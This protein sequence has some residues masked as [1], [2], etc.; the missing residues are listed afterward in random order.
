[1]SSFLRPSHTATSIAASSNMLEVEGHD[2]ASDRLLDR[3]LHGCLAVTLNLEAEPQEQVPVDV[4]IVCDPHACLR[5]IHLLESLR[6]ATPVLSGPAHEASCLTE[7]S[8]CLKF[9]PCRSLQSDQIDGWPQRVLSQTAHMQAL[10]Y[11]WNQKCQ[12]QDRACLE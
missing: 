6:S 7:P 11:K 2:S 1:M 4:R 10:P 8:D 9:C 12:A 3:L 5:E